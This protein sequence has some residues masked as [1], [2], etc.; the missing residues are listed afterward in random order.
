LS[1]G[2]NYN[3]SGNLLNFFVPTLD[4]LLKFSDLSCPFLHLLDLLIILFLNSEIMLKSE[5]H[6]IVKAIA[7]CFKPFL[8][9]EEAQIYCN[10]KRTQFVKKCEEFGIQKTVA[11]YFKKDDLDKMLSGFHN[12]QQSPMKIKENKFKK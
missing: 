11:G 2:I 9:P 1:S 5:Q 4:L 10:L 7:L 3:G 6:V 12:I 8:K